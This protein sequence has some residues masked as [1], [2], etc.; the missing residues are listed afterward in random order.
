M[1]DGPFALVERMASIFEE[2]GVR[3]ALGGSLASSLGARHGRADPA[4][5]SAGEAEVP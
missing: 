4:S 5:P 3:Y 2:L 1:A